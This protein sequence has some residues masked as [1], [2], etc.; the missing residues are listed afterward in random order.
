[1]RLDIRGSTAVSL[2]VEVVYEMWDRD[3]AEE[4]EAELSGTAEDGDLELEWDDTVEYGGS[5]W[6]EEVE[7]RGTVEAELG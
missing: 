5:G 4:Y 3:G 7:L 1:M 6:S 2:G